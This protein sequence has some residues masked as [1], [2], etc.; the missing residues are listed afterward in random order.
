MESHD[1]SVHRR[2]CK[3]DRSGFGFRYGYVAGSSRVYLG[4]RNTDI[5]RAQSGGKFVI[6]A[7]SHDLRIRHSLFACEKGSGSG[8]SSQMLGPFGSCRGAKRSRIITEAFTS[9]R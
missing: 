4:L 2:P 6:C 8:G 1:N 3:H 9:G 7:P 5:L